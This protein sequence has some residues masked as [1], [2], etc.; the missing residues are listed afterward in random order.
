MSI[1]SHVTHCCVYHGCKYCD[2]NCPVENGSEIQKY[3]CEDC[4]YDGFE[5][6]EDIPNSKSPNFDLYK[7]E[8]RDLI[9]E[10]I[11][12]RGYINDLRDNWPKK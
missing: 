7:M 6:I 5:K 8:R 1:G 9:K 2:P 10:C 12:L 3:T 4:D 11:K